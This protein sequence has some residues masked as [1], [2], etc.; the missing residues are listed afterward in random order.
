MF[1]AAFYGA[2]WGMPGQNGMGHFNWMKL[3]IVYS[4]N[5]SESQP[6]SCIHFQDKSKNKYEKVMKYFPTNTKLLQIL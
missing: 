6:G 5:K 3:A 1:S 4:K 2:W